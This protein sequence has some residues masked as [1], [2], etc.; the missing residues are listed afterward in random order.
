MHKRVVS[1]EGGRAAGWAS[2]RVGAVGPGHGRAGQCGPS[3]A[4]EWAGLV[5]RLLCIWLVVLVAV[6]L[7]G[8]GR[9]C[10][11]GWLVGRWVG[12]LLGRGRERKYE[13]P[14]RYAQTAPLCLTPPPARKR[15]PSNPAWR[16]PFACKP[17]H[18]V[19]MRFQCAVVC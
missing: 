17:L 1:T 8:V 11:V 15:I 13:R 16:G 6:N 10:L 14:T 2:W 3:R 12:C 4:G 19:L 7:C 5:G 9:A 18:C